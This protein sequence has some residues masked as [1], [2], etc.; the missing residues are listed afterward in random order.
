M[1][2]SFLKRLTAATV[3]ASAAL[4]PVS[5]A[6]DSKVADSP[7]TVQ[8]ALIGTVAPSATVRTLD[9]ESTDLKDLLLGKKSVLIFYRGGW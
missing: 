6:S 1:Q 4:V 7:G 5:F 8:P 9:G 2:S 3:I